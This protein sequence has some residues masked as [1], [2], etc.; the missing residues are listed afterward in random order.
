MACI[1]ELTNT[2]C[3]RLVDDN[4]VQQFNEITR[5]QFQYSNK[6]D[7]HSTYFVPSGPKSSSFTCMGEEEWNEIV[8][9]NVAICCNKKIN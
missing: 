1:S 4:S 6:I 3:N 5:G 8:T 9:R 7:G 2:F